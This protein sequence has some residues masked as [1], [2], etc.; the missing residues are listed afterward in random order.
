MVTIYNHDITGLVARLDRFYTEL[1]KSVSSGT[2]ELNQF[3]LK[4]TEDALA[5][6][7]GYTNFLEAEP[8][9]DLPESHQILAWEVPDAPEKKVVESEIVNDIL[10]LYSV[11][12]LEMINSQS[13]RKA[14]GLIK[15]D[16]A[17]IRSIYAKLTDY[18]NK[19]VKTLTPLDLPESSP[20][21]EMSGPGKLGT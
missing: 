16:S 15:F 11:L 21:A 2:S 4:R 3:D 5:A 9:L 10:R 14:A 12:R 6:L 13:A 7:V 8:Q 18:L 1:L 20:Q 19:Y 17:R